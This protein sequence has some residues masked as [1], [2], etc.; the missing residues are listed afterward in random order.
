[1]EDGNYYLV[2]V[3]WDDGNP[4]QYSY[5]LIGSDTIPAK[6]TLPIS[7]SRVVYTRF[8]TATYTMDFTVPQ[9]SADAYVHTHRYDSGVVTKAATCTE[10][11]IR[12]YTCVSCDAVYTESI[13]ALGHSYDSGVVTKAA[14]C[15]ETGIRTYTCTHLCGTTYTEPIRALGHQWSQWV[16]TSEATV[17]APEKQTRTCSVC[18]ETQTQ[19][20]GKKLTATMTIPA[21]TLKM[22]VKQSVT[23]FT[24]TDLANGDSLASVTSS[25]TK[26]LKVSKVKANGTFKLTAQKETGKVNLT[27]TLASGKK[28]TVRVTVQKGT[29][30][31]TKLTISSAK[32]TLAKNEKVTLQSVV[33]PVTSQQKVTYTSSNKKVATVSSK[34]VITAKK[35]G[36]ATI[37][38][39]SGSKSVKCVVTVK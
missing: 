11:G 31:T 26:V 23:N 34:G 27:I 20:D 18:K 21:S 19:E 17:F 22:K 1:M 6:K 36:K 5:F 12:T 28:R 14:T 13:P 29:V 33:T 38:V 32:L 37:R 25:N 10:E 8:S 7:Q 24:V 30:K 39:T 2:D 4:I 9:L 35:A 16:T 15:A 3:T